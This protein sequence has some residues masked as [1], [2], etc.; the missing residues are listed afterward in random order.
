MPTGKLADSRV[1][2]FAA[3]D[4]IRLA[5]TIRLV[6]GTT[7]AQL[8]EVLSGI[9]GALRAHPLIWPDTVVVRLFEIAKSSIDIEVQAW[10]LTTEWNEF[11]AIRQE[12][13]LQFMEVVER[14]GT[15]FA[16]PAQTVHVVAPNGGSGSTEPLL[17]RDGAARRVES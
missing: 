12:M 16:L 6:Y 7:A 4:R 1:E 8:R 5:T 9:E 2:T 17:P 14:S 11:R 3:R 15:R 10:F 13:L